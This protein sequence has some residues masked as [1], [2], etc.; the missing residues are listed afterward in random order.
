M[1]FHIHPF[2]ARHKFGHVQALVTTE[3]S[4]IFLEN[5]MQKLPGKTVRLSDVGR[6]R[7]V[8]SCD[9]VDA[10]DADD[11]DKQQRPKCYAWYHLRAWSD[12]GVPE[13]VGCSHSGL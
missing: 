12:R 11:I 4:F 9:S 1:R 8:T 10:G 6:V 2:Y 7:L 3:T 13:F 5:L